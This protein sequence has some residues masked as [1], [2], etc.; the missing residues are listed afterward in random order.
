[1]SQ[2]IKFALTGGLATALQYAVFAIGLY[3]FGFSAGVSSGIGYAAG[4][5]VSY[6]VNYT[7]TFASTARHGK[8][9]LMF[10]AMVAAGWVLNT[11]IVYFAADVSGIN[12]WIS[13]IVATA[14]V[15]IFNF[16]VS[17]TWVFTHD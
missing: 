4:S 14:I 9:L 17:R 8:A 15:F 6:I 11:S 12:P 5:V 10:Y 7:F 13:Q 3:V 1:M 16:W 2:F